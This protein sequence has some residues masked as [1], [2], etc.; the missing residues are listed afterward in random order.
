MTI[1]LDDIRTLFQYMED[2]QISSYE[3]TPEGGIKVTKIQF[4]T[5]SPE[6]KFREKQNKTINAAVGGSH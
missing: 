4:K 3:Q 1:P 5:K 2:L 6:E